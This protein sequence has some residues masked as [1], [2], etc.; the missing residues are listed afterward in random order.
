MT[1]DQFHTHICEQLK[2]RLIEAVAKNKVQYF[3]KSDQDSK[4]VE[5]HGAAR[6]IAIEQLIKEMPGIFVPD[7]LDRVCGNCEFWVRLSDPLEA[8]AF[9]NYGTCNEPTGSSIYTKGAV[10]GGVYLCVSHGC[11]YFKRD[12]L[13]I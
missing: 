5:V 11:E 13:V 6:I 1:E 3:S 12:E 4:P 10:L 7:D 2:T 9:K 8:E